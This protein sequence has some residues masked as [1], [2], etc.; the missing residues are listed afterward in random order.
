MRSHGKNICDVHFSMVS[1]IRL[2]PSQAKLI[3]LLKFL[4][5]EEKI[6]NLNFHISIYYSITV[7][8]FFSLRFQQTETNNLKKNSSVKSFSEPKWKKCEIKFTMR[9]D[10]KNVS[11]AENA[12]EKIS[13]QLLNNKY[14]YEN[15]QFKLFSS[16]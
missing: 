3:K 7:W 11:V 16:K 5:F 1:H 4:Y 13:I 2:S 15:F 10:K 14:F 6:L 12:E 8:K 9:C